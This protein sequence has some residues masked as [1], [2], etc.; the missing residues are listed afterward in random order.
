MQVKLKQDGSALLWAIVLC[1]VLVIVVSGA[2]SISYIYE[3]RSIKTHAQE[4]AY[5]SARSIGDGLV[6]LLMTGSE[7]AQQK[8]L[9]KDTDHPVVITNVTFPEVNVNMGSGS[10]TISKQSD[11]MLTIKAEAIVFDQQEEVVVT[12]RKQGSGWQVI[13]Y[14]SEEPASE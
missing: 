12:M 13:Q 10:A 1:F 7:E 5:F 3:K 6:T 9:P 8:L 11:T 4:Q 2:M 14:D